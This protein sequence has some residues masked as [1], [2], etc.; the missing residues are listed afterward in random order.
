MEVDVE[1]GWIFGWFR[2]T[3]AQGFVVYILVDYLVDLNTIQV[4]HPPDFAGCAVAGGVDVYLVALGLAGFHELD[5]AGT[6]FFN[7]PAFLQ[8]VAL[9]GGK[10][11]G[12]WDEGII[13]VKRYYHLV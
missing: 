4:E 1:G 13:Q 2:C 3:I 8:E 6:E 5:G 12:T 7:S 11:F 10:L 9:D